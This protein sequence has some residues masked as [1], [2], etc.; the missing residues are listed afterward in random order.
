MSGQDYTSDLCGIL[1]TDLHTRTGDIVCAEHEVCACVIQMIVYTKCFDD[2]IMT[3]LT[4][5]LGSDSD[6]TTGEGLWREIMY[7]PTG[8]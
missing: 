5:C 4:H 8:E 1:A 3:G 6:T 7:I 2:D